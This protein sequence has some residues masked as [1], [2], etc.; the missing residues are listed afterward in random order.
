MGGY[1]NPDEVEWPDHESQNFAPSEGGSV[2]SKNTNQTTSTMIP[3]NL[4]NL[5]RPQNQS[6]LVLQNEQ[7]HKYKLT[8][9]RKRVKPTKVRTSKKWSK[10]E[11]SFRE[12][13]KN[14]LKDDSKLI[15]DMEDFPAPFKEYK[16]SQFQKVLNDQEL[17]KTWQCFVSLPGEAQDKFIKYLNE[18]EAKNWKNKQKKLNKN[19]L[20]IKNK[21]GPVMEELPVI[22]EMGAEIGEGESQA[23]GKSGTEADSSNEADSGI[24]LTKE[25]KK[26]K[27][28]AETFEL[29][30]VDGNIVQECERI[31][32]A[33]NNYNR[34][35]KKVRAQ[36]KKLGLNRVPM[37]LVTGLEKEIISHFCQNF[38]A[39]ADLTRE[40]V[41]LIKLNLNSYERTWLYRICDYFGLKYTSESDSLDEDFGVVDNDLE[42][43][44]P[45]ISNKF[46]NTGD[47][48]I[49][50][51]KSKN[52]NFS[53]LLSEFLYLILD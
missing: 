37:E 38:E 5:S 49:I 17:R 53:V 30:D 1:G 35:Q 6:E 20:K 7:Y 52:F 36:M 9:Q 50:I 34:I 11:V 26:F 39:E 4:P 12:L 18:Q 25:Q 19:S 27:Q 29:I 43:R 28:L 3:V 15:E 2:T 13:S 44:R 31:Q 10:R 16:D 24:E 46:L 41:P 42:I 32:E 47:K 14:M 23:E 51:K 22:D 45:S 40:P 21:L 48:A 33:R 8:S